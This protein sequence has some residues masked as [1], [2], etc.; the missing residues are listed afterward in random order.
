M[1]IR[2]ARVEAAAMEERDDTHV[3]K[4]C[5]RTFKCGR[6]LGGHMRS[7]LTTLKLP[8]DPPKK[9][10]YHYRV[11][12]EE[13]EV[14]VKK[15][16]DE[17]KGRRR[18]EAYEEEEDED[19]DTREE[20][21]ENYIY[22][23][24][25]NPRRSFRLS[26]PEFSFAVDASSSAA[27]AAAPPPTVPPPAASAIAMTTVHDSQSDTEELYRTSRK[28]ARTHRFALVP[29]G[30]E[31][32]PEEP[33]SCISETSPEEDVAISLMLLSRDL[34]PQLDSSLA[35]SSSQASKR[36]RKFQC[37][38]CRKIFPS[39][40]ALGGHRAGHKKSKG[41]CAP[42]GLDGLPELSGDGKIH[43]CPVCFRVFGSGQALGGHK[44]TH[45][46]A[47]GDG[48][49]VNEREDSMLDLN[50]PAAADDSTSAVSYAE[51]IDPEKTN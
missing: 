21:E 26:D 9:Q 30:G 8:I 7:H 37:G 40:Q 27:A 33:A 43:E 32:S 47:G 17:E 22:S 29:G 19:A 39:Y 41:S 3:C 51:L 11:E 20:I 1:R 18:Q 24:R 35:A 15:E 34:R 44:R 2:T 16:D 25:E 42:P 48:I 28:R 45:L 6:A 14:V 50:L 5:D 31:A 38:T 49:P 12:E 4:I 10:Q 46:L 23:L 36:R 13:E